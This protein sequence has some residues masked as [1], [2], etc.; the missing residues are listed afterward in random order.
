MGK[1]GGI[2]FILLLLAA[3]LAAMLLVTH[4]GSMSAASTDGNAEA[5]AVEQ[6][7]EVVDEVNGLVDERAQQYEELDLG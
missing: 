3:V 7:R 4:M 6:T 2:G 1:G 5:A